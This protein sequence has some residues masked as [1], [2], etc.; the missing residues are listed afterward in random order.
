M[1]AFENVAGRRKLTDWSYFACHIFDALFFAVI[2]MVVFHFVTWL[3]LKSSMFIRIPLFWVEVALQMFCISGFSKTGSKISEH[4]LI[5]TIC[6]YLKYLP[7]LGRRSNSQG[8]KIQHCSKCGKCQ[9][10]AAKTRWRKILR[11]LSFSVR[12]KWTMV[13]ADK[14]HKNQGKFKEKHQV[15]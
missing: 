15:V 4:W 1:P 3:S 6:I 9:Q 8:L 11:F 5:K 10:N 7:Y 13:F 2:N 12:Q 14:V